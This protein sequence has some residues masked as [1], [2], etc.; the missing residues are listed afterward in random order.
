M[1]RW[2]ALVLLVLLPLQALWAITA[3][4]CHFED[5]R[6]SALGHAHIGHHQHEHM[7]VKH[8]SSDSGSDD[9]D[10]SF[11][12]ATPLAMR[13]DVSPVVVVLN[14]QTLSPSRLQVIPLP[15][16]HRP[17]RPNWSDLA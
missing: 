5:V 3:P 2:I 10:C 17:E 6:G 14:R 9:G 16:P 11:C 8:V 7:V 15:P 4:Y 13:S 1:H 12:H